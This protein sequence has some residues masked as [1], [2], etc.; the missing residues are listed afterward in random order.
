VLQLQQEKESRMSE[1]QPSELKQIPLFENLAWRNLTA[2]A[3]LFEREEYP[4]EHVVCQQGEDPDN[5]A[6]FIRSGK[7]SVRH[8]DE[9]GMM[10]ETT[11]LGPGDFFGQI[12]LLLDEPQEDTVVVIDDAVLLV[13]NRH[14]LFRLIDSH[15]SL[16]EALQPRM[17]EVRADELEQIHLFA[18]L[19][20][21]ERRMVVDLFEPHEYQTGREIF[22]QAR[23]GREAYYVK[24]GKLRISRVDPQG[25]S[26]QVTDLEPGDFVGET[27]LLVGEPHDATVE[28]V[29]TAIV[30]SLDK[31]EFEALL[32]EQPSILRG[33]QMQP[34]VIKRRRA[35]RIPGQ[36][37]DET[38]LEQLHKHPVILQQ[39]L[40]LPGSLIL[41]VLVALVFGALTGVISALPWIAILLIGAILILPQIF[42]IWYRVTDY[43]NDHYVVTNKRVIQQERSPFGREKTSEASLLDIQDIQLVIEGRLAQLLKFGDLI[44]DTAARRQL[45]VFIQ[46]PDPERIKNVIFE[47]KE[48]AQAW[49]RAEARVAIRD[50][51][52]TRFGLQDPPVRVAP[53]PSPP[54]DQV[55]G[56]G[57]F[58]WLHTAAGILPPLRH[59]EGD[60]ITWRKHWI[61]LVGPILPPSGLIL[62]ATVLAVILTYVS[63]LNDLSL[64]PILIGYGV[65]LIFPVIWWVWQFADWQNDTYHVTST[66]IIDIEKRPFFGR[67]ERREADLERV[68]NIVVSIPGP[69][70]RLLNYG[71]VKI[72]TAGEEPFTFDLVQDPNGVRAEIARHVEACRKQKLQ[73]EAQRRRDE[74][75]EWFSVYDHI[76]ESKKHKPSLP[77]EEEESQTHAHT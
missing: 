5:K 17:P 65:F 58:T 25:I 12:S 33:L 66:R 20:R 64:A 29:Q 54:R 44:I 75:L 1:I 70:A 59:E 63:A 18:E 43:R 9:E 47:Q 7:L 2:V 73:E 42:I 53:P 35:T 41:L 69:M 71:S 24:S 8:V 36:F 76:H 52:Q 26:R 22:A 39:Q 15:P 11:R 56:L 13:L 30:L 68:E 74:L 48:R 3:D 62:G 49:A 60:T 34:E 14:D 46:I 10:Y 55:Q 67:E 19:S 61:A 57:L 16:F 72:E 32:K 40:V 38:I 4:A 23:P 50:A 6:Y 77:Q 51:L 21:K 27:S 37:S 45:V 31:D 28:V